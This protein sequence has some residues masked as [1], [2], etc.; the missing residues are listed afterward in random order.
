MK[1]IFS[2]LYVG[3]AG[4][5]V[6]WCAGMI[7]ANELAKSSVLM[8][9]ALPG[10]AGIFIA[11]PWLRRKPAWLS[12]TVWMI[13][14]VFFMDAGLK[15]FLR[16]YFGLR[17]N[18]VLVLQAIINT[19][20]GEADEFFRDNWRGV[21]K[22]FSAVVLVTAAAAWVS[23]L[24]RRR[25]SLR[26]SAPP[27]TK[28]KIAIGLLLA[29][30]IGLHFNPTMAKE[31]PVLFWPIRFI[32]YRAQELQLADMRR[33]IETGLGQQEDWQVRYQGENENT[34]VWVI[35][36]SL[37]RENMSLY[38]YP[39]KT[40]PLLDALAPELLVFRDVI[41]SDP[42]TMA[43]LM[44]MLT[45][46]D[47]DDP[48]AW[49]KKPD[50]VKQAKAAGFK[51][52]WLSNQVPNDGWLGLVSNQSDERVFINKGA[53]RG[54]NNFDGNLLPAFEQALQ[55]RA[56]RK[57]V[58]VHLLGAHPTY[59]M[60]YPKEFARFNGASDEISRGLAAKG[61]SPWTV[62]ARDEYDNAIAY[63]DHVVGNMIGHLKSFPSTGKVSLLF[64][65]DHG[66]EV[67]HTRDHA[68]QSVIDAS[69]YE[70]PMILWRKSLHPLD[71]R[72]LDAMAQRPYQTDQV[73]N[74]VL[75]LMDVRSNYYRP[76]GDV[77][78][79]QFTPRTRRI[80]GNIYLPRF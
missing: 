40:T 62:S 15:G 56:K 77:L 24:L 11:F 50:I 48:T 39:R 33:L 38:G 57:L 79:A 58:V 54:E 70:T 42:A 69:G 9:T 65:A 72:K 71:V 80:S 55:D 25:E 29:L 45:P 59:S 34:V 13:L 7:S 16:D 61:R 26:E 46:A 2:R 32:D 8:M 1:T 4:M 31:N 63:N 3:L 66:Q 35:G 51:T 43:S 36:E 78:S 10:I 68:G 17:P 75:G 37:N 47:T 28:G 19:N 21:A 18:P 53:G 41:S 60:R 49:S 27:G 76:E 30:F 64:N 6:F 22:A 23:F 44:K 20:P 14:L 74:T 5:L 52:F 12:F 67:G 73:E